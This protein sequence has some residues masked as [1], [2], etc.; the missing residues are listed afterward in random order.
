MLIRSMKDIN[1]RELFYFTFEH[2][3][4]NKLIIFVILNKF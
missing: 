1:L 3:T 2:K 4:S